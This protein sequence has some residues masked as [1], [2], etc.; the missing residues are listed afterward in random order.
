M[1]STSDIRGPRPPR[2]V[3]IPAEY[4]LSGALSWEQFLT[5]TPEVGPLTS[6]VRLNAGVLQE[7]CVEHAIECL[8]GAFLW[9]AARGLVGGA[10]PVKAA[11][12]AKIVVLWWSP[13][14]ELPSLAAYQ[15]LGHEAWHVWCLNATYAGALG[16][17]R[18]GQGTEVEGKGGLPNE[19]W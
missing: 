7:S 19:Q 3:R 11:V 9:C 17:S 8:V 18:T 12:G 10:G 16:G 14:R 13:E 4:P 5:S 1:L 6:G 2:V 15:S